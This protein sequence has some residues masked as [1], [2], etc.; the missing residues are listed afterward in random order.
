LQATQ[1]SPR[2]KACKRVC[3]S[4]RTDTA[5]QR[6]DIPRKTEGQLVTAVL[7]N[8]GFTCFYDS[9]VQGST[10]GILMN[11]CAKNPPLRKAAKRQTV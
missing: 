2:A 1:A 5:T 4:N 9:L 6:T 8:G 7:Q 11:I 3:L 10:F